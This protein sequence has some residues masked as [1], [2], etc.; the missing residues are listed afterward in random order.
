MNKRD[1]NAQP[2]I[3]GGMFA[4]ETLKSPLTPDSVSSI[5]SNQNKTQLGRRKLS[6]FHCKDDSSINSSY[7]TK[8]IHDKRESD[9]ISTN[10]ID[11]TKQEQSG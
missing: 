2:K 5:P 9:I 8:K 10:Q 4:F 11:K 6:V 3:I 1:F 7:I